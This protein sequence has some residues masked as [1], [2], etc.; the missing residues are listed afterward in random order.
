MLINGLTKVLIIQKHYDFLK[1]IYL[2][3]IKHYIYKDIL[4]YLRGLNNF[5]N[6][7]NKTGLVHKT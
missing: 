3:N 5:D 4:F 2:V 6:N 7:N 1:I